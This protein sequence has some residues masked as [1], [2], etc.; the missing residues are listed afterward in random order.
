MKALFVHDHVFLTDGSHFYSDKLSYSGW[1]RYLVHC[2]SLTVFSRAKKIITIPSG[3]P[4]S[5]GF[6]VDFV[7]G[8]SFTSFKSALKNRFLVKR[9]MALEI[10]A[11]DYLIIRLPSEFGLLAVSLAVR[12]G[13]PF[14]IELAGCAKDAL[15][16]YGSL[17]AKIYSFVSFF[18]TRL[19][20]KKASHVIYVSAEYLQ[21]RYPAASCAV[22]VNISNVT[23]SKFYDSILCV[24]EAKIR[25]SKAVVTLGVIG[26]LKTKYKGVHTAIKALSLL[27]IRGEQLYN[28][29]VLGAGDTS[30]YRLLA[31]KLQ[32]SDLVFFDGVIAPGDPVLNWID[33]LDIYLQPSFT[34]GVP[35][36]L[37]EAM[38]RACP[39]IGSSAGG[40]PE[41]LENDFIFSPG[42]A[43]ALA[44]II[45]NFKEDIAIS[46]ARRNFSIS[47]LYD[48]H[49]LEKRRNSFFE[50]FKVNSGLS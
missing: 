5:S 1:E 16:F 6:R 47:K 39:A 29:R 10:A 2:S 13:K 31:V 15:W 45:S 14:I 44:S 9:K 36:A 21:S 27:R 22:S 19:A 26:S 42:D 48:Y 25:A 11:H 17:K 8:E 20:V 43:A 46:Q 24:R 37:I 32:V 41:L 34:E 3:F 33:K 28:L 40:I 38:S 35:R 50:D 12:Q 23:I 49:V 18:R 30:Y 7:V 4:V